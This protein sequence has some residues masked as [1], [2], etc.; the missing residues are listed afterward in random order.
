M[1]F[2][3]GDPVPLSITITDASGNLANAGAVSVTV[4]LPDGTTDVTSNIPPTSLGVYDHDYAAVQAGRH[5]V[6]WVATGANASAF[7]DAF[8]VEPTDPDAFISL[9]SAVRFLKADSGVDLTIW[10]RAACRAIR[11]R[12]G[13]VSPVSVT[14]DFTGRCDPVVL[15]ER[16]VM[17]IVSV[18]RLPGLE[19]VPEFDP[20]TGAAGWTRKNSSPVLTHS[21]GW[22]GPVRVEY[23]VGRSPVPPNY[24]LAAYELTG[25]LWRNSQLNGSGGRPP[26]SDDDMPVM[27]GAAFALSIRVRELLGIGKDM[28]GD[29]VLIA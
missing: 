15:A 3:L 8:L 6:R 13:H 5:G 25:H 10:L 24:S 28:F 17:E 14:E 11:D 29:D 4:T 22:L 16:P 19:A 23:R 9:A 20:A 26:L 1:S 7:T 27:P 2:D 18:Q 12:V 21:S